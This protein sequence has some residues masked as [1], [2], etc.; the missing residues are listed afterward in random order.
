M[1]QM[2]TIDKWKFFKKIGYVPHSGQERVHK[3][4][5]NHDSVMV[6][7]GR[8]WGKSLFASREVCQMAIQPNKRIWIVAPNYGLCEK[9]WREV[10][11]ILIHKLQLPTVTKRWNKQ[12]L[13]IKFP[14]GTEIV[15]KQCENPS[16]LVG[17]ECDLIVWDECA[18]V[19]EGKR[20]WEANLEPNLMNRKG[21]AIF[22]STP[23]GRNWF[24]DFF[25]DFAENPLVAS[26]AGHQA[27]SWDNPHNP[28]DWIEEKRKRISK[29][30]FDQEYGALFTS[31]I[32][33]AFK[34]FTHEVHILPEIYTHDNEVTTCATMDF[35]YAQ[36]LVTLYLQVDAADNVVIFDEFVKAET[37][38]Y[39][40]AAE[41]KMKDGAYKVGRVF[42]DIAGKQKMLDGETAFHIL[43]SYGIYPTGCKSE[44]A[45][46]LE[47]IRLWLANPIDNHP[48]LFI[49]PNCIETIKAFDNARYSEKRDGETLKERIEK[50]G[51]H[52][53][54]IDAIR[55][56]FVNMYGDGGN[57]CQTVRVSQ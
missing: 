31:F 35:G 43:E 14:W 44:Q 26:W 48:K 46:G 32:G 11:G 1:E 28:K 10:W 41:L 56:F 23:E 4:I 49:S 50:D 29:E 19:S 57:Y 42:A 27:P 9:V 2:P 17:D 40:Q 22:I 15:G 13:I 20:I 47:L 39:Q 51:K 7:C 6:V 54:I 30:R 5:E 38:I 33:R 3:L 25:T 55:Y 52:D 8:R 34:M 37:S 36:R 18:K 45:E 16:S 21:K 24:Y 12:E 53:H